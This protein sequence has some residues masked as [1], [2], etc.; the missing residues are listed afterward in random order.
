MKRVNAQMK[1]ISQL[2]NGWLIHRNTRYF[3][4]TY[5]SEFN[6]P[7]YIATDPVL[8]ET[9]EFMFSQN[10]YPSIISYRH[11]PIPQQHQRI[12]GLV[13]YGPRNLSLM[14]TPRRDGQCGINLHYSLK[15]INT[16]QTS[17]IA[18]RRDVPYIF[19]KAF[20]KVALYYLMRR[21]CN[22]FARLWCRSFCHP[23][24]V[25]SVKFCYSGCTDET[26]FVSRYSVE[27]SHAQ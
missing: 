3:Q 2:M 20:H 27:C 18:K 9:I 25:R 19:L 13:Y 21:C 26:I 11:S 7:V 17:C 1:Q 24:I 4:E 6:V 8:F 22:V 23:Q 5:E 15:H 12:H 16:C 10:V 14:S